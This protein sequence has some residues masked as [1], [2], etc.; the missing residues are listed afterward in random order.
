ML[1]EVK[2]QLKISFLSIKYALMK[3]LLNKFTFLFNV[4]FMILNNGCMIIEWI[5]L[6]SIKDSIGGYTLK[7]VVLLWGIASGIYGVSHFFFK[8]SFKLSDIIVNGKLDAFIVQPKNVLLSAITTD[9]EPSAIGDMI[10]AYICLFI[11]GVSI[12]NFLLFTLFIITGG[13]ITTCVAVILGSLSF[14]FSKSDLIADNGNSIMVNFATY[15][16]GIFKGLSKALLTFVIPLGYAAYMPVNVII[17]F[18]LGSFLVIIGVTILLTILSFVIFNLGLK[19]Y[20]SSNL[21]IARI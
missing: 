20:S 6:F 4:I 5:I 16:D 10:Y 17:S 21:M 14:F 1:M 15:P 12:R 3:E 19:K 8:N 11:Y 18:N 7:E 2:N 9:V 13:I